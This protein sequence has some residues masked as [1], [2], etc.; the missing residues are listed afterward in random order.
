VERAKKSGN[1]RDFV[2]ALSYVEASAWGASV[3]FNAARQ[4]NTPM[5]HAR[6]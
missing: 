2:A 1:E 3:Q 4:C 6:A 5:R